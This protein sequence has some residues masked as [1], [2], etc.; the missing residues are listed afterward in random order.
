MQEHELF[1]TYELKGWQLSRRLYQVIGVSLVFN[2][3]MFV[4][5]AQANFL[6]GKTCDSPIASGVCSVLDTLYVGGLI[7]DSDGNFVSKPYE[8]TEIGD[9]DEITYINVGDYQPLTYPEGYFALANPDQMLNDPTMTS[10]EIPGIST[11]PTTDLMS[12]P[13]VLPK[14]NGAVTDGKLED[15]DPLGN[16]TIAKTKPPKNK[17]TK[18]KDTTVA[19]TDPKTTSDPVKDGEINRVPFEDAADDINEWRA[20][21][22]IDLTKNFEVVVDGAI[23]ADGKFDAKKTQFVK[24]VGDEKM[25][26]AAKAM[27]IAMGDSGF[28]KQLR[29]KGVERV[30]ITLVQNDNEIYAVLQSDLK[31]PERAATAA[32]GLNTLLQAAILLDNNGVKKLDET[33]KLL[34]T[35]STIKAEG[36]SFKL[37]FKLPKQDAQAFIIQALDKRAEKKN[38]QPN[39]SGI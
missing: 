32:T 25:V 39:N 33:S 4:F 38:K 3:V 5:M 19:K 1:E 21:N 31:T 12:T 9:A 26:E 2:L 16:P 7:L 35:N 24:A 14:D 23:K 18:P 30:N 17:V 6:T 15:I 37:D 28:L 29:D 22:Q 34:V 11:N 36:K 13:Q 27:I 10:S 20:N 8:R